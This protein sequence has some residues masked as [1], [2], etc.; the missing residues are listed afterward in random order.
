MSKIKTLAGAVLA[1]T[2]TAGLS[3]W[4]PLVTR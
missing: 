3:P 1:T 4:R 2:L